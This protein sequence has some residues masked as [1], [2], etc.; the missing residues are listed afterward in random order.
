M[1][2]HFHGMPE[3]IMQGILIE[4]KARELWIPADSI[5]AVWITNFSERFRQLWDSGITTVWE[6]EEKMYVQE[7]GSNYAAMIDKIILN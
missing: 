6:L 7:I 4:S 1:E 2:Q 5:A 3:N